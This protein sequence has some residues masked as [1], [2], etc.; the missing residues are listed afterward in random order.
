MQR[1]GF[2]RAS[3]STVAGFAPW[4]WVFNHR[5]PPAPPA[6]GVTLLGKPEA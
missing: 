4:P 6:K 5:K 1:R 2:L 3:G